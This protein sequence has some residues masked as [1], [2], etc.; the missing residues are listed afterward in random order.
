MKRKRGFQS[1]VSV[2]KVFCFLFFFVFLSFL[3]RTYRLTLFRNVRRRN[4][5]IDQRHCPRKIIHVAHGVTHCPMTL[6]VQKLCVRHVHPGVQLNNHAGQ[7]A[8]VNV[9]VVMS[10]TMSHMTPHVICIVTVVCS[11]RE[12]NNRNMR[13]LRRHRSSTPYC[14]FLFLP[15]QTCTI[16]HNIRNRD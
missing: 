12:T 4:I 1:C 9:K 16:V 15:I 7:T 5:D 3:G 13:K 11:D 14:M 6:T 8:G 2:A 10:Q